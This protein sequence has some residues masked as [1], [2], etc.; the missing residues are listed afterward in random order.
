MAESAGD[1][2]LADTKTERVFDGQVLSPG[3][4]TLAG[5][6]AFRTRPRGTA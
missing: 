3:H 5:A 1:T 6:M 2:S 4:R